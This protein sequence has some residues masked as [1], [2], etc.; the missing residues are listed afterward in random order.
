MTEINKIYVL[1][2]VTDHMVQYAKLH[3]SPNMAPTYQN[4]LGS[5]HYNN[6]QYSKKPP[7]HTL[8]QHY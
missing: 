8:I 3:V 1:I 4:R 6:L 2:T 7:T 5:F